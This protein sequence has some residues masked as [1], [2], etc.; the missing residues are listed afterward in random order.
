LTRFTRES[1]DSRASNPPMFGS[2]ATGCCYRFRSF[3]Q[4]C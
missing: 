3:G 2:V 1:A 4:V